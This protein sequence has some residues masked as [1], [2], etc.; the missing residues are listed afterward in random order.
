MFM[1][2]LQDVNDLFK[3]VSEGGLKPACDH[4]HFFVHAR[5]KIS[6]LI[7]IYIDASNRTYLDN[8]VWIVGIDM[9]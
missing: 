2:V 3:H 1:N 4:F 6:H 5:S 8:L 7:Q 9:Y